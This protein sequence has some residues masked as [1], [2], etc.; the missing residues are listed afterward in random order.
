MLGGSRA[1][2]KNGHQ[3]NYF[4]FDPGYDKTGNGLIRNQS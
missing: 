2:A 1:Y 4:G 3:N